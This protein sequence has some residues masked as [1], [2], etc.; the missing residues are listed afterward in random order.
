MAG[1]TPRSRKTRSTTNAAGQ[2]GETSSAT[3]ASS[4]GK[5]VRSKATTAPKAAATPKA[6]TPSAAAS[7]ARAATSAPAKKTTRAKT[8][9]PKATKSSV[10]ADSSKPLNLISPAARL[11]RIPVTEVEPVIEDGL[12]PVKAVENESFPVRATV[13][14]EGHDALGAEVVLLDPQGK[15]TMRSRMY[16]V[17]RGLDRLEAWIKPTSVGDWSFR[18]DTFCDPYKTWTKEASIKVQANQDV[19]MEF[20]LGARLFERAASGEA[21]NNPTQEAPDTER[22]ERLRK[23]AQAMR[24]QSRPPQERL[25]V[26]SIP[27]FGEFSAPTL[28]VTC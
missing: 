10:K 16:D 18:V 15:E 19:E 28:C 21:I 26:D 27:R 8:A 6:K 14:R 7:K 23:A 24:D 25:S 1:D 4:K 11:A 5:H 17:A 3:A 9:A 2:K 22:A 20:E 12:W 13:F